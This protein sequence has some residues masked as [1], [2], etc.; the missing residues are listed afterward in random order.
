MRAV[1]VDESARDTHYYFFGALIVDD[2]AAR[3][4]ESGLD[5]IGKL[6]A[7][8]VAGF[9]PHT[10]FH[11]NEMFHG[12]KGWDAVPVAWRVKASELVAKVVER[13]GAEYVF[14][15]INLVN[16][17]ARYITP[18]P[19]HMLTLA[20]LLED[21]DGRIGRLGGDVAIVLADDHHSA[22]SSRRNLRDF[23]IGSVPGYTQGQLTNLSD[24]IYFGPSHASRLLQ[25]TDIATYF[26]NRKR[27]IVER[28]PRARAALERIVASVRQRL[29]SEY[30]W[31][32]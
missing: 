23:K 5:G 11:G 13:S 31:L 32:D 30:V 4:I 6:V 7:D 19:P 21:V 17:R 26:M 22:A 1:Y 14:R 12:K 2:A 18:Y 16:H 20:Q 24:T 28:D 29:V 10:E 8:N 27:T 25:A 9:D 3:S 15:G